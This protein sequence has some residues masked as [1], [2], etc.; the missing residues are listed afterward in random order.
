M[1]VIAVR[2]FRSVRALRLG[3]FVL[4]FGTGSQVELAHAQHPLEPPD[5]SSPRQTLST[6]L[7]AT[8]QMLILIR[9]EGAGKR[10]RE[11]LRQLEQLDIRSLR[12]LDMSGVAPEA[13]I[14]T[15]PK[16]QVFLYEVLSRIEVPPMEQVPGTDEID[17]NPDLDH[18]TLPHTE[19]RIRRVDEG[20]RRGEF[21]FDPDTVARAQEFYERTQDLPYLRQPPIEDFSSFLEVYGGWNV[22]MAWVDALPKSLRSVAWNLAWW[23]WIVLLVAALAN[24]AL[25][26]FVHRLTRRKGQ[27]RSTWG[28]VFRLT[29]PMTVFV[30]ALWFVPFVSDEI[31]A[32]GAIGNV[33][34]LSSTAVAYVSLAWAIWLF[35]VAIGEAIATRSRIR[36]ESLD[37]S[38]IR[39]TSQVIG[40]GAAIVLVFR[41]ADQIGLPLVGL[42]A[43]ISIG[44]LAIALA[45]QD[46]LKSLLGSLTILVDQPYRV[47]ERIVAGGHDGVVERIGLRSTGIRQLDGNV[48]SIPNER[49]ATMNIE[50]IGR[51]GSIRRK[52][53]LR[54]ATGTP[55]EK[56]EQA[57]QIVREILAN[58]EGMPLNSPARVYFDEFNPDSLSI[59][60]FY[61][62][63]PP[64]YWAFSEFS[65]RVNFEIIRRFAEAGIELAPPTSRTQITDESGQPV[66][67]PVP[68]EAPPKS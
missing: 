15:G 33:L 64:D 31:N 14:K 6:F 65:E 13:R 29:L 44:G 45:A 39:L 54:I 22:P 50:N 34:R 68:S 9:D 18:W 55:R 35:A 4:L 32:T 38:L 1:S 62:Y 43:S 5:T 16:V 10:T 27:P 30:S 58:H 3:V 46:T 37:A 61:W 23:K 60:F 56:V 41:G 12:T 57:V 19:I 36:A 17:G 40:M 7:T 26:L 20:P 25:I 28:Y 59:R 67:L 8:D 42:V 2:V 49:M 53:Q 63:S 52:A 24:V 66:A 48:T 11:G 51:R 21:L 47:G